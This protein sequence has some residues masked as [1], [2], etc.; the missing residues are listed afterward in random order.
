MR[1]LSIVSAVMLVAATPAPSA[2][3]GHMMTHGKMSGH[4]MTHDKMSGHMK[5]HDKMSGDHMMGSPAPKPST[6]P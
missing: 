3:P 2:S 6:N 5:P 4:M 1:L